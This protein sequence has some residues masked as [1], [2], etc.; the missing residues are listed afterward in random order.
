MTKPI[1][2]NSGPPPSVGWWLTLAKGHTEPAWRWRGNVWSCMA[3][4]CLSVGPILA[5]CHDT[6]TLTPE[7]DIQWCDYW[8]EGARVCRPVVTVDGVRPV[9]E[10]VERWIALNVIDEHAVFGRRS[11]GAGSEANPDD[12]ARYP[13]MIYADGRLA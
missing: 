2:W 12:Y 10:R 9:D 1:I 3:S 5:M 4:D 6:P 13:V 8:P 7:A 11:Y